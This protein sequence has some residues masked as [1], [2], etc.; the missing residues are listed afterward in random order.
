MKRKLILLL[1][2]FSILACNR[3]EVEGD[4]IPADLTTLLQGSFESAAHP[5][6]GTVKLA[7]DGA[8]KKY[9]VFENFKSDPGPDLRIWL[10]EDK[11]ATNYSELS[12]TVPSGNFKIDVPPGADTSTRTYV[13]I[14]CKAFTVLFGSAQ[15]K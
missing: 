8:G 9:L 15:L 11:S 6:S 2:S 12:T 3:D 10:A 7:K 1:F 5:T 14:W 13:L 4:P